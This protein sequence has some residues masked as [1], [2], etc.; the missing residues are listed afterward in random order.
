MREAAEV[1]S[2]A[3]SGDGR[4]APRDSD[5]E[6][7][8][9]ANLPGPDA[10]TRAAS[11]AA[12][13]P[14]SY[15]DQTSP[16][17][18]ALDAVE[19]SELEEEDEAHGRMPAGGVF[20]GHHHL[21]VR[22]S[23]ESGCTFRLRRYGEGAIE[24]TT[25]VPVLE[26]FGLVVL[27]AVPHRIA[28]LDPNGPVFHVD[29]IGLRI[30][31]PGG[32]ETLRFVPEIHGPRLVDALEAVA[33][34]EAEVDSLNRLVTVAGL[35]WR[36]VELL[37]SYMH[38][39]LQAATTLSAA[40]LANPLV[41]FP[42][43]ARALVGYFNGRFDPDLERD[44]TGTSAPESAERARCVAGLDLVPNLVDDRALRGYLGL[45]DA[46]VRTNYFQRSRDGT[47][48]PAIVLKLDSPKVPELPE[49]RPRID[50]FVHGPTLE[51]IHLRAGLIAR[52]GLRWSDRPDDF[53]TEILDLAFAQVKK[54][55][56]IVPTGAKGGFV[57]RMAQKGA[58]RGA[59]RPA[60]PHE[61]RASYELFVRSLL[62]I[63][64]NVSSGKAI[65]PTRVVARDGG[66]PYLVVAAD[67]GTATFS[68]LA[69]S[70][71]DEL[72]FW[73]GDAFAS[74]GSRGYDH[75]KL[76]I[77]ARGAWVAVRRHFR[78]LGIDVQAE[79]ITVVG[80]GDMSG[81]VF[82]NGMLQSDKIR[83][84]AAFDHR[85]VFIDPEPDPASSFEERR[86]LAAIPSSSWA[87][88]R[89]ELISPGGGVW[90]RDAK[91]IPLAPPARRALGLE[92]EYLSPPEVISGILAAPVDLLWF[93]GIGTFIK[94]PGEADSQVGD[95][96][97]D[98][99][100]ITSDRVRVRV[101]AEGGNL[102][103]T[104]QARIRYSRRGGR[105]NTDFVDN[106]A[107]VA[108]SDREVNLKI[109]LALAIEEQRLDPSDRDRYLKDS[110]E[111]VTSD[112]L[113]QVDHNVGALDRAV[114]QSAREPDAF[115]ALIDTLEEAGSFNRQV[116]A[117][118]SR[119]ELHIRREAGGGLIRPELAVLL[120]Y[121]RSHLVAAIEDSVGLAAP[122]D[123][124]YL[125]AVAAYF[126]GVIRADFGDLIPRHRLFPQLA[127]TDVAGEVVDQLGVVWAHE[128]SAEMGRRLD[129]VAAAFWAAREVIG[130]G[131]LWGELES[132]E[133][134]L[135]ADAEAAI[136][137]KISSAVNRLARAYLGRPG[138]IDVTALIDRDAPIAAEIAHSRSDD[139]LK[140]GLQHLVD[141]GV[142]PEVTRRF[143][144]AAERG[145][146]A[147]VAPVM[148]SSGRSVSEVLE[149]LD[150]IDRAASAHE[151][152][153]AVSSAASVVPPPGRSTLWL[154]R[155]V[156]DDYA[157]WKRM[158]ATAV[159]RGGSPAA[160]ALA[161]WAQMNAEAL[162]SA[163]G[164]LGSSTQ[165]GVDLLDTA[166]LVVRRLH[167][168]I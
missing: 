99:V 146:V 59:S 106:A 103:I 70:I 33:R 11:F 69:N 85:H 31:A 120:A 145:E 107:G 152:A 42:D 25:F 118:P 40:Q 157:D 53:R 34:G 148:L 156:L 38:Y 50:A 83:L 160:V 48:K 167:R 21:A 9:A 56:I 154:A 72:G 115:A 4:A 89:P 47:H 131:S 138:A 55:A 122:A 139:A 65:T 57:C 66:D 26:S 68:D 94:A 155:S 87:D 165:S 108:T 64:D 8:L 37:R 113:R 95:H 109:L 78:Q 93:G 147:D 62:E 92:V 27:D 80:V 46:T 45:I 102:G 140:P 158:A 126:P 58:V 110:T 15:K 77:T 71:S 100:R 76:G 137:G 32:E 163:A 51:G 35:D 81:D 84:V 98:A 142:D 101:I 19:L 135:S 29:D 39:R 123:H 73:L 22:P 20:G 164:M 129:Q 97:N 24:L 125:G 90:P 52:G 96:A 54:N 23:A 91:A 168:A 162:A 132:L 44:E 18:A 43:I 5:W 88:Y 1:S 13:A 124:P 136:H 14:A 2:R 119:E 67:K 74:G 149:V 60:D 153:A 104:Q 150:G 63:T 117:L 128:T 36:Q 159:L 82:G 111:E 121:A 6:D 41:D 16:A 17:E 133:S 10:S 130:A 151:I 105:I 143:L 134:A 141:L 144:V 127:A 116:E 61:V 30:D 112:V 12:R 79:P 75:K 114:S 28:S 166:V 49:P 161:D 7:Q 86:R 3:A